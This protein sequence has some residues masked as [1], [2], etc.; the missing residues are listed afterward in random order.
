ML[1]RAVRAWSPGGHR[2]RVLASEAPVSRGPSAVR[3]VRAGGSGADV[4]VTEYPCDWQGHADDGITWL[5]SWMNLPSGL[6]GTTR[7]RMTLSQV[8]TEDFIALWFFTPYPS[9][10]TNWTPYVGGGPF[11][12][13]QTVET[14]D[15][16][17]LDMTGVSR[18][19][20][21]V[22]R[23]ATY[24]A[25]PYFHTSACSLLVTV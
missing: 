2:G 19:D 1:A 12:V 17:P 25:T 22:S 15:T 24:E 7:V 6:A 3:T 23:D 8:G 13:G 5:A 20:L 9:S 11:T 10:Y 4:S 18:L 14:A 21:F 16:F